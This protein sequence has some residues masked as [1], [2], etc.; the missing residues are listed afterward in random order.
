MRNLFCAVLIGLI[1]LP[2]AAQANERQVS[3]TGH[4]SIER[5]PDMAVVNLGV[6][7][8]D[9]QATAA[10]RQTSDAAAAV[11]AR[12]SDLG[13]AERDV[14][15]SSVSLGPVWNK[16]DE[17]GPRVHWGYEATN[18][19]SVRLRD[20]EMVGEALD[21][22]VSGGANR[23]SNIRFTLQDNQEAM[24]EALRRAVRDARRKA[25]LLAD[26]AGVALGAAVSISES[27][28]GSPRPDRLAP[29]MMRSES[30][31][32]AAGEIAIEASVSM[33]FQLEQ[34]E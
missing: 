20:M 17:G 19:I 21:T 4:A 7:H 32:I 23:L 10:L 24:D 5:A 34:A 2:A 3:V 29:T 11:L 8:K 9:K 16:P 27:G 25:A 14:Q 1:A 31:P 6:T 26:A 33:V 18:M 30:V 13:V 22:L 12:L 15:T 28:G